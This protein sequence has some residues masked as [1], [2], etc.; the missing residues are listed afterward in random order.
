VKG[1]LNYKI[2]FGLA[3]IVIASLSFSSCTQK[4]CPANGGGFVDAPRKVNKFSHRKPKSGLWDK[5]M[6]KKRH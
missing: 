2:A 4:R 5:S 3:F 1:I 6:S